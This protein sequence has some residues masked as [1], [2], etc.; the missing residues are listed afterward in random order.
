M[1]DA[2]G[3]I[4]IGFNRKSLFVTLLA[5]ALF[6][7]IGVYLWTM[8]SDANEP[9]FRRTLFRVVGA[10]S[11]IFSCLALIAILRKQFSRK[12]ALV[13]D[14]EGIVDQASPMKMG[15]I[16]WSDI[17]DIAISPAAGR[18]WLVIRLIHPE[19][20]LQRV[21]TWRRYVGSAN[22]RMVGSPVVIS[23]SILD[24]DDGELWAILTERLEG[25]RAR[26]E[27]NPEA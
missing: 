11:A 9:A 19:D 22:M 26:T 16:P 4:V 21:S 5:A 2:A 18:E 6:A 8:S 17:E 10:A 23:P 1:N 14:D 12:A 24:F 13:I 25:S 20:Y 7:A 3:T 27:A 15:R